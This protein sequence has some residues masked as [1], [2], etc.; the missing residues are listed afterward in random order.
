MAKSIKY[1][2]Y[3]DSTGVTHQRK[4]LDNILNNQINILDVTQSQNGRYI[5]SKIPFNTEGIMLWI[6]QAV[7]AWSNHV[8]QIAFF[9]STNE[10]I[11]IFGNWENEA[12]WAYNS[13]FELV[14]GN[15]IRVKK[16][17]QGTN[18]V[19]NSFTNATENNFGAIRPNKIYIV[20]TR[21]DL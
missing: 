10:N 18:I 14:N 17:A 6:F 21:K 2:N 8:M 13:I 15:Q 16:F 4:K 3:I 7:S 19:N 1:Q 20:T 5:T 12:A 11:C 9:D